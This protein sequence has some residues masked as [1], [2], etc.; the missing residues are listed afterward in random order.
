MTDSNI[1]NETINLLIE[2]EKFKLDDIRDILNKEYYN[3]QNRNIKGTT[4]KR[5]LIE[6]LKKEAEKNE[7]FN[8]TLKEIITQLKHNQAEKKDNKEKKENDEYNNLNI[9]DVLYSYP[10]KYIYTRDYFKI[11]TKLSKRKLILLKL[12]EKHYKTDYHDPPYNQIYTDYYQYDINE[13]ELIE[14]KYDS[15][16]YYKFNEEIKDGKIYGKKEGGGS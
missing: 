16:K 13:G 12:N 6:V 14:I 10:A 8:E 11:I 2:L 5:I 15:N 1:E 9:N 3:K 4:P 7:N